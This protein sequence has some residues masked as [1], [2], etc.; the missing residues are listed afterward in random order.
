MT[1]LVAIVGQV[2]EITANR[3]LYVRG[4]CA[5]HWCRLSLAGHV[6]LYRSGGL[7]DPVGA[8]VLREV[9]DNV[10][11][12]GRYDDSPIGRLAA[13][14]VRQGGARLE[15]SLG[16]WRTEKEQAVD[17]YGRPFNRISRI[18]G[19]EISPV[20][21]GAARSTRTVLLEAP[22][23]SARADLELAEAAR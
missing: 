14:I 3:N 16:A 20:L 12:E 1:R 21:R 19:A 15:W 7:A 2:E 17:R 10:V 23:R 11:F 9:G 8:G 22:E 18:I 4:A 5:G 6:V 13:A